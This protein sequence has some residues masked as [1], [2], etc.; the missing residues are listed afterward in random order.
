MIDRLSNFDALEALGN[1]KG[2][3]AHL[4]QRAKKF[5][6]PPNLRR[7]DFNLTPLAARQR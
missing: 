6:D 2:T 1:E 4:H 5:Q 7:V 3:R